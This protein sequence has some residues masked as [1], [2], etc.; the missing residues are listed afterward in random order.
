MM[1]EKNNIC[2]SEARAIVRGTAAD[3]WGIVRKYDVPSFTAPDGRYA[4][5]AQ[6]LQTAV[7]RE[8]LISSLNA[9]AQA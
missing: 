7:E 1:N 4:F 5:D 3:V 2:M 9:E 6:E 8:T